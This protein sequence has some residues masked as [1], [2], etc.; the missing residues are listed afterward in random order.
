M[1]MYEQAASLTQSHPLP[2]YRLWL[3]FLK[4]SNQ[5]CYNL[6]N[7]QHELAAI[8][9]GNVDTC[10]DARNIIIC[11]RGGPLLRITEVHPSYVPLHFPL[12]APTGQSGWHEDLCYTFTDARLRGQLKWE[13]ITYCDFLKHQLHICPFNV[14]SD[15]YFRTGFLFQ[16]YIIDSWAASEHSHLEWFWHNQHV[17]HADL[18]C[19]VVDALREGLDLSSVGHKVILPSSFTLG[20]CFIQK[21]LQDALALLR[22][23][24]GSD[25]F[26]TFTA[27]PNW[28]EITEALLPGQSVSDRPDIIVRVFH[29]K[30]MSLLDDIMNKKIFGE[31]VAYVYMVE[32]QK[33]G[34]PPHPPHRLFESWRMP[35]HSRMYWPICIYGVPRQEGTASSTQTCQDSHG[36]WALWDFSLFA[37]LEWE[38][39]MLKRIPETFSAW[40]RNLRWFVRQNEKAQHWQLCQHLRF[41]RQQS[42]CHIVLPLSSYALSGSY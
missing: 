1:S 13:F 24:K 2:D 19:G 31:G 18:Y 34:L 22:I 11:E 33:Q 40:N 42:F 26:I 39:R 35:F 3:K 16:E 7:N 6:L 5:R 37:M 12:L 4:A 8:I 25:L 27:N 32:Y 28:C 20:P 15:H 38:E 21:C 41:Q 9:P 14:E 23:H 17:I 30:V 36:P 29:L 10:I